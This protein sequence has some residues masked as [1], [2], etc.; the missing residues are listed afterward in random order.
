MWILYGGGK[1]QWTVL[2]HNGPYFPPKYVNHNV[3]I[4]FNQQEI[5][6]PALA[7]EYATLYAKYLDTEYIN[8][9]KFNKNFWNDFKKI[10]P[11]NLN[12]KNLE[13]IDFSKIKK[14]LENI[15]EKKKSMIK[16]EKDKIKKKNEELEEPYKYC[17]IDGVTQKVGNF[18]IEPPGIFLGR[19]IHPK[20]G[21]IKKRIKPEDII[22]NL[23]KNA[24]IPKSNI[25][26][27]WKKVIHDREVIWLASWKD[28]ITGKTKYIFTSV[29]SLFKSK[30]DEK[31]FNL[32]KRLKKNAKKIRELYE[33]KLESDDIKEKQLATA[34]YFIDFLALRVGGKKDKKE[35]ADTVGVTSLR[36][37]HIDLIPPNTIKLD[38]LGKDSIRYCKRI[39]VLKQVYENLELL[40]RG[41]NKKELLFDK[42][43]SNVLNEYL[44]SFL[45][46]LTA[47]VW[48]TYNASFLFQKE[49][50]KIRPEKIE[51]LPESE[52]LN[53]II[54][55]FQQ[56][57]A[58]VALLCNHQKNVSTNFD[59]AVEKIKEKIKK[60]RARKRKYN[61]RMKKTKKRDVKKKYKDKIFKLEAKIKLLKI[62]KETKGK[63]KNVSLGTS[64]DNYIDPRIIFAFTK[65]FDISGD[66]LGFSKSW[67]KRF[68][69]ASEVDKNYRF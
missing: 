5:I 4:L 69:W 9:P 39:S 7:E 50:D 48:R 32:A 14:Y 45:K 25:D 28:T 10:L 31:K 66:K 51:K 54:S 44:N 64:K 29:E 57:N 36:V 27:K 8:N 40:S 18:R 46:G 38:F 61:E 26:G 33:L 2:R 65:K 21:S 30:S 17:V 34:L 3:P 59:K 1:K 67:L 47:K 37:E 56:A 62:K 6:L 35:E 49:L 58:A 55:L 63:M 68:T 12:I 52:R 60:A 43:N 13:D 19:G 20:T 15:K 24:P 53:F 41:K 23:D 11:K 22:I 42:I 16:E